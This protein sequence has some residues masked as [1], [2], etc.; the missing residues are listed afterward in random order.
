MQAGAVDRPQARDGF[1]IQARNLMR[2]HGAGLPVAFGTD[3][4]NPWAA[5]QEMADMVLA[6]ME[7][8]DVLVAATRTSAEFLEL[9]DTGTL[10]AGRIADFVILDGNPLEDITNTRRIADVYLRGVRVDREGI[11]SRLLG[12]GS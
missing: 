10:E 6:G 4:S 8:A 11:S 7:P 12:G 9:E 3:G 1:G 2:I 5:H